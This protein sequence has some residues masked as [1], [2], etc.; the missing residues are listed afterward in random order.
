MAV[1]G[2]APSLGLIIRHLVVDDADHAVGFYRRAFGADDL[3]RSPSPSG[4]RVHMHLR[5]WIQVHSQWPRV[6]R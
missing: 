3:Y 2:S 6:G 4:P 5:I 1:K